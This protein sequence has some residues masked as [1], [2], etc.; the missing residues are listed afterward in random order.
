[1]FPTKIQVHREQAK[2]INAQSHQYGG[3]RLN[4]HVTM[5]ITADQTFWILYFLCVFGFLTQSKVKNDQNQQTTKAFKQQ[6][7]LKTC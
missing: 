1:M 3:T 4:M 2:L 7:Q 5:H 6:K